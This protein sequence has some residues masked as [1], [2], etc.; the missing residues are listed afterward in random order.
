MLTYCAHIQSTRGLDYVA[1]CLQLSSRAVV[2]CV[3][4]LLGKSKPG[5]YDEIPS[6]F[7]ALF[8]RVSMLAP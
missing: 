5:A 4:L 6:A 7:K 2:S 3:G 8:A 1:A